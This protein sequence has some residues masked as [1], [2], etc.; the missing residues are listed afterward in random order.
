MARGPKELFAEARRRRVFRTTGVYLVAV[1]GVSQGAAE[2]APLFG[3]PNWAVR[4]F[5]IGSVAFLPVVVVL[6]WMFDIGRE[7]IVRD[8]KDVSHR[9]PDSAEDRM[10]ISNMPTI[11][12]G[13]LVSG[14]VIVRWEDADGE[15]ARIFQEDFFLGRGSD[16]RVRFYDPLVS[17]RH[18]RLF[19]EGGSWRLEDLGSRN[20]T[21]LNHLPA[22]NS[23]LVGE[24]IVRLNEVGPD[25]RIEVLGPEEHEIS[26]KS[27]PKVAHGVAHVRG[28]G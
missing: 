1:F 26:R 15:H 25:L 12:G 23:V 9:A 8:P 17:R 14:A 20:G 19:F 13:Q 18:A 3:A 4:A 6:A 5:V 27:G 10:D 28:L 16:C 7:G 21:L 24:N 11:T 2:L 22:D